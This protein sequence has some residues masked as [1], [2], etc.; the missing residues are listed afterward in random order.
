MQKTLTGLVAASWC[1]NVGLTLLA[2]GGRDV[3][4]H[5]FEA[6]GIALGLSLLMLAVT[7]LRRRVTPGSR[8]LG[9]SLSPWAVHLVPAAFATVS[10]SWVVWLGPLSDDFVLAKWAQDGTWLPA[11]SYV[12]PLP[13]ALWQGALSLSLSL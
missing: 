4:R 5:N 12:R 8:P 3:R 13:L 9:D 2:W 1:W 6:A 11:W 10:Y 7:H